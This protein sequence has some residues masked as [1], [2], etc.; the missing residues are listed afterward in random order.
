MLRGFD[1]FGL[2][3]P[4]DEVGA[5]D[6]AFQAIGPRFHD[7][8]VRATLNRAGSAPR[9]CCH[10]TG[11]A[12]THILDAEHAKSAGSGAVA[13]TEHPHN[14]DHRV[15]PNAGSGRCCYVRAFCARLHVRFQRRTAGR[16][17]VP[18]RRGRLALA[19]PSFPCGVRRSRAAGSARWSRVPVGALESGVACGRLGRISLSGS[20]D[21]GHSA[22][23]A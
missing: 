10:L 5:L 2:E 12:T 22:H 6:A 14:T 19:I 7:R 3:Q 21:A 20:Y 8:L 11:P 23:V 15:S 18:Q 17:L 13:N 4:F 9:E 16:A 1:A